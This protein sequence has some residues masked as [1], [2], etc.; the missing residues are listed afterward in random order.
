MAALESQLRKVT[1]AL[2]Q[3]EQLEAQKASGA[4]LNKDQM[5]KL[6]KKAQLVADLKL[7]QQGHMVL[8]WFCFTHV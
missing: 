8:A 2:R 5:E 7:L 6:D 4:S 1:K 3:I